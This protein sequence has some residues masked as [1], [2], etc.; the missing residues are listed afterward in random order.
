MIL[1][2]IFTLKY[3]VQLTFTR[4]FANI[5]LFFFFLQIDGKLLETHTQSEETGFEPQS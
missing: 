2:L 3:F 1:K 5:N 4:M